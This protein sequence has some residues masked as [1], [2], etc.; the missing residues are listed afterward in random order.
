[1]SVVYVA[2]PYSHPDEAVRQMRFEA[3]CLYCGMLMQDG[4]HVYSPIAH[5]HPMASLCNLP[6]DWAYWQELD[7]KMIR[8]CDAV[9]VL[10]LPGW[11]ESQGIAA[12]IAIAKRLGKMITHIPEGVEF[13]E[14]ASRLPH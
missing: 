9:Y 11:E 14:R 4:C 12:E 3:V 6:T 5:S 8:M 1:M 13:Y 2:S 10:H 7:E